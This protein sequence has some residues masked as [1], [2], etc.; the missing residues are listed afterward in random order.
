LE[1][2]AR[3]ALFGLDDL[4]DEA[5]ALRRRLNSR[6]ELDVSGMHEGDW[7]DSFRLDPRAL[8]EGVYALELSVE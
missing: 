1:G 2:L 3:A 5:D 4:A 6:L 7:L 8:N